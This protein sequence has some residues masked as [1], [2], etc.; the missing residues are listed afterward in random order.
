MSWFEAILLSVI[1]GVTEFL[2]VS[3]S[4][5]LAVT[6]Q[7]F[8]SL[9][10]STLSGSDSLFFNVMLHLGTLAAIVWHYRSVAR[11]A[12]AGLLGAPDVPP[13]FR[14]AELIRTGLLTVVATLPA[15]VIGLGFKTQI[16]R[17]TASPV[18]A[19]VGFLITAAVLAVTPRLRAGE[20]GTAATSW[21]DA[22]LIGSAQAFAILPGVSRSGMTI[23]TALAL[24]LSRSWSVGFSL[25][26]A[27]VAILGAAVLEIKDVDPAT[28]TGG[29]LEQ[30]VVGTILAG[31]V[32]YAAILWLIRIVRGNRLWYF[33]VYLVVLALLVLAGGS[34]G[35]VSRDAGRSGP[36]DRAVRSRPDAAGLAARPGGAVGSVAGPLGAGP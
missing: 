30:T 23:V 27:V 2:P 11:T 20:K 19:G 7:F 10:G 25:L 13:A 33:S 3:S 22:L 26:M 31:V 12:A 15:V 34:D 18:V 1:Q 24:G 4:G 9:R 32:G 6:E 36:V 17:A 28:L 5:H 35:G 8:A 21:L 29:R 14:R 16:E